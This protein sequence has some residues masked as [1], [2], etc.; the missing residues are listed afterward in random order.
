MA[1]TELGWLICDVQKPLSE[2]ARRM[3][4][5]VKEVAEVR[6]N[7]LNRAYEVEELVCHMLDE[8]PHLRIRAAQI[9]VRLEEPESRLRQ[10]RIYVAASMPVSYRESSH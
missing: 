1:R 3:E 8:R 5:W 10:A 2:V 9:E 7:S 6:R 4:A